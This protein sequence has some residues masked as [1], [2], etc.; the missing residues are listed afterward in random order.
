[1]RK[2]LILLVLPALLLLIVFVWWKSV[3][4]SVNSRDA[5]SHDFLITR[6]QSLTSIGRALE[7]ERLIKSE[8]AFR[9]YTQLTKKSI[10]A[11]KYNLSPNL[12]LQQIVANH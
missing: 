7:K 9:L 5:S 1:M 10:Q 6:G 8:L 11:G 4:S 3:A 12:N 2:F